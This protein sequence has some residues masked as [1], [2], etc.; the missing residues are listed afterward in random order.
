MKKL[1]YILTSLMLVLTIFTFDKFVKGKLV[2][3][4]PAYEVYVDGVKIGTVTNI[5]SFDSFLYDEINKIRKTQKY[6]NVYMPENYQ[7]I[8][9]ESYSGILDSQEKVLGIFKN[10]VDF[11]VDGY[12]LNVIIDANE[13]ELSEEETEVSE[14]LEKKIE[15]KVVYTASEEIA[16]ANLDK[17]LNTFVETE[18][19]NL[20]PENL[21]S[22][23]VITTYYTTLGEVTG[24]KKK[25]P[26]RDIVDEKD[27]YDFLLFGEN[28]QRSEYTVKQGDTIES[29]AAAN[30]LSPKEFIII[31]PKYKSVNDIL[32][33]GEIVEIRF[34]NPIIN[35]YDRKL[36]VEEE[37]MLYDTVVIVNEDKLVGE[38]EEILT[39]GKN[40]LK[41]V[42]FEQSYI[43]GLPINELRIIEEI[44]VEDT[45]NEVIEIGGK[46]IP[47]VGTGIWGKVIGKGA[48]K[49]SPYGPRNG[50][51][52]DGL[53]LGAP[54]GT[55]IY[56]AD[57]GVVVK[58]NPNPRVWSLGAGAFINIDHQNGY[59]TRYLHMSK[60]QVEVGDIVA[61]GQIIGLSGNSGNSRGP[62]LHFE[63]LKDMG[64]GKYVEVN[65]EKI[66][67]I[68]TSTR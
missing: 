14:D 31:N 58:V 56:A 63:V 1:L 32:A 20:N 13:L 15:T 11:L 19:E 36:V 3:A 45:V 53:D 6:S 26:Y 65:P 7:Y 68:F 16:L 10:Q 29:I 41:N 60:T 49:T 18:V 43:N 52:H 47:G 5:Q 34:P 17:L 44:V 57:N 35:I 25:V 38:P 64:N 8:Q 54:V 37:V 4:A 55:P 33:P 66:S 42:K 12:E 46:I 21:K 9:L 51:L 23:D 27:L 30:T 59:I 50:R 22:G 2:N 48:R 40:G 61:K 28:T 24:E 39:K 67:K 62:H